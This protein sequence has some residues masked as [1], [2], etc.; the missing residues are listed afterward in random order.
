MQ[1]NAN[2][3]E[4]TQNVLLSYSTLYVCILNSLLLTVNHNVSEKVGPDSRYKYAV[5]PFQFTIRHNAYCA[6]IRP[7]MVVSFHRWT[8][9]GLRQLHTEFGPN[10][11]PTSIPA[12][13]LSLMFSR[14]TIQIFRLLFDLHPRPLRGPLNKIDN[15]YDTVFLAH[16]S[17]RLE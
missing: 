4:I 2:K 9:S 8:T 15:R 7:N 3:S 5:S 6:S 13:P 12:G 16:L 1:N 14:F 11:R 10:I 17:R